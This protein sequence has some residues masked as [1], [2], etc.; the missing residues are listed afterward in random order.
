ML[1]AEQIV[2]HALAKLGAK[3]DFPFG[4]DVLVVKVH[5]KM[6]LLMH[7]ESKPLQINL[8]CDP[9]LAQ[10]LRQTY[11]AVRPGYHMNKR[12]WNTVVIDGSVPSEELL[13]MIDHSY[14]EVLKTLPK[15]VQGNLQKYPDQRK[16]PL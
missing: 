8:K 16:T 6:F 12:H 3:K 4:A 9:D 13:G 15:A 7:V 2:D 1:T 10:A 11:G 14:A 5:N